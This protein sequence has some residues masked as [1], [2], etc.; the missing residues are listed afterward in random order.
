MAFASQYEGT[1]P[2]FNVHFPH[3]MRISMTLLSLVFSL[4]LPPY[5]LFITVPD[6]SV[7]FT[8]YSISMALQIA[9]RS[10][11]TTFYYCVLYIS[12]VFH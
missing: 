7:R 5:T 10:K 3:D 4:L 12:A 8:I 11:I 2:L 6:P 9:Q 1:F